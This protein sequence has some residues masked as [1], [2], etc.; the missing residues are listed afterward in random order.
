MTTEVVVDETEIRIC[1]CWSRD[2]LQPVAAFVPTE[3]KMEVLRAVSAAGVR[4]VDL[5][6]F[7][8][9]PQFSDAGQVLA[10]V[11]EERLFQE[12]RVLAINFRSLESIAELDR[13]QHLLGTCGFPISA[14]E[15]HNLA[16]LRRT[17]AERR[18]EL[19]RMIAFCLELSLEPLLCIATAFGCPIEGAV[20][21]ERIEDLAR[22]ATELGI[23]RL[24]LGDTTGMATP[25]TSKGL[26]RRL[27]DQFPHVQLIAHFHDTRGTG[28]ANAFAAIEAGVRT[29]DTS[30]GGAGGEP[31]GILVDQ[32]GLT[33]NLC[34]EDFVA[35][36]SRSGVDTGV[37]PAAILAAGRL[38]EAATGE[39][40]KSRVMLSGP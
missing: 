17:T 5:T 36:L 10:Q 19:E 8:R 39:K 2:G 3:R 20:P 25:A 9:S 16:N 23:R 12:V 22:W 15:S 32:S 34:T 6:G 7:S 35:V 21:V 24:M 18:A 14:S 30:L 29:F 33:G 38:A 28:M 27:G 1:E 40:S 37:D 13:P 11:N 31:K 4:E 26:F